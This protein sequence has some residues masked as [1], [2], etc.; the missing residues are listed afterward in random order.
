V[1]IAL[2]IFFFFI[3]F[4]IFPQND[5][6]IT[7]SSGK[8]FR[9]FLDGAA[10]NDEAEASIVIRGLTADTVRI[11]AEFVNHEVF[12]QE[13]YLLEKGISTKHTEFTYLIEK[14]NEKFHLSFHGTSPRKQLPDPMVPM[15]PATDTSLK[16]RNNQ[17]DKF[18]S[19]KEGNI[20]YFNNLPKEG[21]CKEAMPQSYLNYLGILMAKAQID[22][23]KF[24]IA[25]NTLRNN[26]VSISQLN[27][28]LSYIPF[29]LEKIKLIKLSYFHLTDKQ[30]KNRLD[31]AFKLESSKRELRLFLSHAEEHRQLT[32]E[33]CKVA[34]DSAK[35]E[36]FYK[37]LSIYPNDTE[38]LIMFRKA[39]SE[40]CYSSTQV[41]RLLS[42]FIHEAEKM[43]AAKLLYFYCTDKDNYLT[44]TDVFSYN[45][46]VADLKE[47]VSKQR[48]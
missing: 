34:S 36:T 12:E 8:V 43:D 19:I 20:N 9:L 15:K 44:V 24:D 17:L 46:S 27:K 32:G 13:V 45:S 22:D 38:K 10:I 3:I 11:R 14:R 26:C 16:Y 2:S 4:V 31:S 23:D 41:H 37:R 42:V 47:F 40:N 7:N 5:L 28:I 6:I 30:N 35:I 39:Y 33:K 29:E 48:N 25:E 21:E 18:C 1:R